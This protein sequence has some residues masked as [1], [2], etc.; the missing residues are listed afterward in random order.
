[1]NFLLYI[2]YNL[3]TAELTVLAHW[4]KRVIIRIEKYLHYVKESIILI[5]CGDWAFTFGN[6]GTVEFNKALSSLT[7][8]NLLFFIVVVLLSIGHF[9]LLINGI[10]IINY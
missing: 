8:F 10:T 2:S 3:H 4:P 7:H 6:G 5:D 1:M 9:R